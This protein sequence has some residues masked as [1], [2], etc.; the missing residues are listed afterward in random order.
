LSSPVWSRPNEAGF[1]R[2]GRIDEPGEFESGSVGFLE[3]RQKS[4]DCGQTMAAYG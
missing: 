1:K 4:D 2:V 3:L